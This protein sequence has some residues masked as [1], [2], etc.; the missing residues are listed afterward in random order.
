MRVRRVAFASSSSVYGASATNEMKSVAPISPYGVSKAACEQL[1]DVY[2]GR[3]LDIVAM[4]YFTVY[5]P[6]QRPDM[7]MNRFFRASFFLERSA[8]HSA[9]MGANA[10]SSHS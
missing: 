5:G 7:A 2:R 6:R 4:R 1:A 3:G 8:S 10:E 9:V